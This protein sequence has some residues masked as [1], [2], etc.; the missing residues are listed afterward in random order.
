MSC[1]DGMARIKLVGR[2]SRLKVSYVSIESWPI[3]YS[4]GILTGVIKSEGERP[5]PKGYSL[6]LWPQKPPLVSGIVLKPLDDITRLWGWTSRAEFYWVISGGIMAEESPR[7]YN[8]NFPV[9]SCMVQSLHA[10]CA[11]VNLDYYE[12]LA[13]G[14][15]PPF[16]AKI[17]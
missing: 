11:R 10:L 8:N 16:V 15:L 6:V 7:K 3:R 9:P 5:I 4:W 14:T 2:N 17:L 13:N 12:W 1:I